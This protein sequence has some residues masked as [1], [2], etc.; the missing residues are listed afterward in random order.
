MNFD[1]DYP[2]ILADAARHLRTTFLDLGFPA[3]QAEFA[4]REAA[5][6]LRTHWGGQQ[7][8]FAKGVSFAASQRDEQIWREFN[9]RNV[10]ELARKHE[11]STRMV[12][13]IVERMREVERARRQ[14]SLSLEARPST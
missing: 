7:L 10:D 12:L 13:Y 14:L 11:L 3:E 4:A 8:Y 2:E 5:E 6:F 9:G 1:P